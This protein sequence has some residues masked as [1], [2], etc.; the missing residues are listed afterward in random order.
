M[1]KAFKYRKDKENHC[2]DICTNNVSKD[3]PKNLLR[4]GSTLCQECPH[5]ISQTNHLSL[6]SC[7]KILYRH[8]TGKVVMIKK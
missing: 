2:L 5:H 7:P 3:L 8:Y 1:A 4:V 6:I